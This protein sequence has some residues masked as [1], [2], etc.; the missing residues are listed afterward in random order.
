M[1]FDPRDARA[2]LALPE[3]ALETVFA[4]DPRDARAL[5][6]LPEYA[7]ET[8]FALDPRG[9][10]ALLALLST[11]LLRPSVINER[12]GYIIR[13]YDISHPAEALKALMLITFSSPRAQPEVVYFWFQMKA[14]IF[15]IANL[16][17]RLQTPCSFGDMAENVKFIGIPIINFLCIYIIA[18][19]PG[20]HT[21]F[22]LWRVNKKLPQGEISQNAF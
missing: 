13:G 16:K 14:H 17:F 3:Y 22:S 10:R 18:S 21:L 20:L 2:F 7:L 4:L 19:S 11:P 5:L 6:A 15:L 1:P 9:A 12:K 8:V